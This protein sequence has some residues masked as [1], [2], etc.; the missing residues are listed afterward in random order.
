MVQYEPLNPCAPSPCG[1][2][3]H[4]REVNGQAVCS[5]LPNYT[6]LPPACRPECTVS[7]ECP[8]NRACIQQKC[9]DPCPGVCGQNANCEVINHSP[10]CSCRS[11]YTGDPFTRCFRIPRKK[12]SAQRAAA[13]FFSAFPI[14]FSQN[15][16]AYCFR[17]SAASG[18]D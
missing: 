3:S 17:C 8:Q 2:N 5:C 4:C 9:Q 12:F 14:G 6:G 11:G 18:T 1:P 16:I 7:A 13:L 10:I 15:S